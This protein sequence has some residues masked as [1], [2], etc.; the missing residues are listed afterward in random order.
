MTNTLV[1]LTDLLR[2][3][4]NLFMSRSRSVKAVV[5]FNSQLVPVLRQHLR[6]IARTSAIN[7]CAFLGVEA[8]Q[9]PLRGPMLAVV[10]NHQ[11]TCRLRM[12][13]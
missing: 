1:V 13:M 10:P 4:D 6:F 11:Q 3:L 8:A 5:L 9:V 7:E 2:R 12:G